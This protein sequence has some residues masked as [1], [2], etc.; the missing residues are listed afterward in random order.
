[1]VKFKQMRKTKEQKLK[2]E[3]ARLQ[4]KLGGGQIN[5]ADKSFKTQASPVIFNMPT[6]PT[7]GPQAT[8]QLESIFVISDLKK[9]AILTL[10]AFFVEGILFILTSNHLLTL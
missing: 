5:T 1:M 4:Q 3:L 9:I 2:A 7:I 6:M 10:L 8:K